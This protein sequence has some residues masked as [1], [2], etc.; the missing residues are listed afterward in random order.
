MTPKNGVMTWRAGYEIKNVTSQ[1]TPPRRPILNVSSLN[2]H[3]L[4]TNASLSNQNLSGRPL[5]G[6]HSAV[7]SRL[8][9]PPEL[10]ATAF[11]LPQAKSAWLHRTKTWD[12]WY[13]R[14]A[15][16]VYD[17]WQQSDTQA[18]VATVRVK[19]YQSHDIDCEIAE[20]KP[21]ADLKRD[22]RSEVSFR[23][24]AV[25]SVDGLN[26]SQVWEFPDLSPL[27]KEVIIDL[28]LKRKVGGAAGCTV[29]RARNA[30]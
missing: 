9:T 23:E 4:N 28:E 25:R 27:P 24:A 16:A 6:T 10:K 30:G 18:G 5:G 8:V 26:R 7:A 11:V 3:L 12:E 20:F 17:Q 22:G 19:V 29:T 13:K 15:K 2:S 14:V 1:R 21:A